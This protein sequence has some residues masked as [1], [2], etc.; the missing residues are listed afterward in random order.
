MMGRICFS[1]RALQAFNQGMSD[2]QGNRERGASAKA[3]PEI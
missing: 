1:L 3:V 2:E